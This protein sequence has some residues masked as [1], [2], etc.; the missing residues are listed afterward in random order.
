MA[1]AD[2]N[3]F[4]IHYDVHGEGVPLICVH[5]LACDR[6]AWVMQIG[7]FQE[8]FKAVFFDN[9][10]VGQSSLATDDYSTADMAQDVLALADHL[11]LDTFHLLGVSL[12]G[13]VSQH[14][15]LAAPE[16]VRSLTLAVTHGGV[17]QAGRLRGRLLGSYARHLPLEDRVDNLLYLC[18]TEAFFEN[19]QAYQFMRNALLDNPYPQPPEAF[20]RQAAAGAHHDLR[21]RLGELDLPVHVIGA[22]RDLM[23]PVWKSEELAALIPGAKLTIIDRQG[24]GVLWEGADRFNAVVTEFL[25]ATAT[26]A[27]P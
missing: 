17:Q 23:I 20:A 8:R 2:L 4:D 13:M 9:R 26:E 1:H 14:V 24:H 18:Y 3:G 6:R 16:R 5:G 19:E 15:A 25:T 10:D 7:P 21:D 27:L 11:E 22:E 12:G